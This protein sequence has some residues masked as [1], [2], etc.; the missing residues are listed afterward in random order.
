LFAFG[1]YSGTLRE[2][3]IQFKFK[4]VTSPAGFVAG[5]VC[6]RFGRAILGLGAYKLVPIPLHSGREH[7]RGYNQAR[8]F[9]DQLANRLGLP[10][11]NDILRRVMRRKPQARLSEVERIRNIR[12]VFSVADN[13]PE[14]E[15]I[16]LVD[17]VVTSG[18]TVLEAKRVLQ[19]AGYVVPAV[20]AMAHG[21]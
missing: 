18:S 10:V 3:I 17:D 15:R 16:I 6:E 2:T 14:T 5:A 12:G 8:L 20:I 7:S 21:L 19:D 1:D 11:T 13:P 4:G 9:A